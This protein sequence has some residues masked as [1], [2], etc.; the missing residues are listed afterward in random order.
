M[1]VK[2]RYFQSIFSEC[3]SVVGKCRCHTTHTV[4]LL[5]KTARLMA[6][7]IKAEVCAGAVT[8]LTSIRERGLM[9][10][11]LATNQNTQLIE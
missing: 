10:E 7:N 3:Y 9:G 6:V 2:L 1:H 5:S 4:D 8:P 11:V